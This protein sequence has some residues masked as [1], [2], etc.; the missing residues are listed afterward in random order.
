M[1]TDEKTSLTPAERAARFRANV[2]KNPEL[3]EEY[4]KKERE[5]KR[6][7]RLTRTEEQKQTD[8]EKSRVRQ[9]NYRQR[10][11]EKGLKE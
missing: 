2:K 7:D 5:R 6:K 1:K 4:K 11:R 8:R 10:L 3:W 9:H